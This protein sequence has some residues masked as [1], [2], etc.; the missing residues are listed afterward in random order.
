MTPVIQLCATGFSWNANDNFTSF[1]NENNTEVLFIGLN[2][3][4][5]SSGSNLSE[6]P[7][8]IY[9]SSPTSQSFTILLIDIPF[10]DFL[11]S[12]VYIDT[13]VLFTTCN[14][15]LLVKEQRVI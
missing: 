5:V 3:E 6:S 15:K 8:S 13:N 2:D 11:V 14:R 7:S 12:P 9:L 10:V 4:I 1:F